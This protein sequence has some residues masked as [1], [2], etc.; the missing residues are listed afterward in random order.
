MRSKL[1]TMR[2]C[3]MMLCSGAILLQTAGCD[4]GLI[5]LNQLSNFVFT[6]VTNLLL[7]R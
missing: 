6:G 1:W 4:V 7:P 5:L 2:R 3:A